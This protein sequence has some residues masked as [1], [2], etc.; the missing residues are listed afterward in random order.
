MRKEKTEGVS[1]RDVETVIAIHNNMNETTWKQVLQWENLHKVS[2]V[3]REPKLLRF[4]GRPDELSPKARLKMLC[5]HPE[6]FDRHDWVVDRGGIEVRYIIDY[7]H[8]ESAVANDEKPK[9]L[10]DMTSMQSIKVDV[11]P[12]LDSAV[13]MFD[14]IITMPLQQLRGKTEYNPPSFFPPNAMINAEEANLKRIALNWNEIKSNCVEHKIKLD[15]CKTD[16][17]CGAASVALQRCTANVICPSTVQEFDF[18]VSS[19]A[20]D[21]QR[22]SAAYSDMLKCLEMFEID[23][24]KA[25]DSKKL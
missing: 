1:E 8:D 19:G 22:T 23:S 5:G 20:N 24:R 2:E 13:S 3:G 17:E 7:Y 12:A 21:Q 11:R 9:Y 16:L 10:H 18:C 14:R 6:P 15:Q 4:I 25:L